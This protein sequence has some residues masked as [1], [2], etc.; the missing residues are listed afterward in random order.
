[1]KVLA[2][3]ALTVALGVAIFAASLVMA[4]VGAIVKAIRG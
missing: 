2:M 3:G 1:M 4:F